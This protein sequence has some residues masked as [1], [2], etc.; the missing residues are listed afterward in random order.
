MFMGANNIFLSLLIGFILT[1]YLI[2]TIVF[3][4]YVSHYVEYCTI[5]L[6]KQAVKKKHENFVLLLISFYTVTSRKNVR[7]ILYLSGKPKTLISTLLKTNCNR[8]Y[9]MQKREI[10]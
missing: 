9:S 3:T 4:I 5:G 7:H 1:Q 10:I 8:W 2:I 6:S